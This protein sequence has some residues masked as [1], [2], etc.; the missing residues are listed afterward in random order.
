MTISSIPRLI[1][2]KIEIFHKP[3]TITYFA[4]RKVFNR[5]QHL[6]ATF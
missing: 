2:E 1:Y 6:K 3:N 4:F 5:L